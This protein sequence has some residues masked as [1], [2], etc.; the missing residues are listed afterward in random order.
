MTSPLEFQVQNWLPSTLDDPLEK[1]T[2]ASLRIVAGPK[3]DIVTKVSDTS[4][5]T[6]RDHINVPAS[7]VAQWLLV[8][9]W[10][11]RWEPHRV[12]PTD[13]WLCA[14]SLASLGGG[15]VWPNASFGSFGDFIHL[16]HKPENTEDVSAIRYLN[17]LAVDIPAD[18][19][20]RAIDR[21]LDLVL[22]RLSAR[23]SDGRELTELRRELQE[24]RNEPTLAAQCRLQALAGLDPG[25]A[26][27]NWLAAA[28][29]LLAQAGAVAGDE[30]LAVS[31]LL[32]GGLEAT[33]KVVEAM[34][35]STTSIKFNF[36]RPTEE[37]SSR[38]AIPWVRGT[39]LAQQL[40]RSIG[41]T[42]GPISQKQLGDLLGTKLPFGTAAYTGSRKLLGG[43]R[44]RRTTDR[45]SILVSTLR[46]DSQRFYLARVIA[47]ACVLD[48]QQHVLPV[49]DAK[50][51]FQKYERAFAQELLCPWAELD[52]FT[53]EQGTGDGAISDA[54]ERF[55]VSDQLIRATLSNKK[56]HA[57]GRRSLNM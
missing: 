54:A 15:Y 4:A 33:H 49:S 27:D 1:E 28:N 10:R 19:F 6:V 40:R 9:W 57:P 26:N 8:N 45:A 36:Q 39:R 5:M 3:G 46:D 17:S 52:A 7:T 29:G 2:L 43:S 30:L 55:M 18:D 35:N 20:E 11:L 41:I 21:F 24:E 16:V 48:D 12:D 31:A 32:P 37:P 34:G 50:T 25:E 13:E 23:L 42:E 44:D 56:K 53:D 38:Q 22:G 47:A 14:H 51:G